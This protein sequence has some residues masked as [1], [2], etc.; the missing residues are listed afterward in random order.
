MNYRFSVWTLIVGSLVT[1]ADTNAG[2][3]TT[4]PGNSCNT[5]SALEVAGGI[6]TTN[7]TLNIMVGFDNPT[8]FYRI[9][10][11]TTAERYPESQF[12]PEDA[13]RK[14]NV[15]WQPATNPIQNV[16][17]TLTEPG[18]GTHHVYIQTKRYQS[19]CISS[20]RAVSVILAPASVQT[21]ALGGQDLNRFVAEAK[22]RGY[23]FTSTF[24]FRKKD[25]FWNDCGPN[26]MREP[27]N[28]RRGRRQLAPEILDEKIEA[29]FE[30]F[31]G[32]DLKPFWEFQYA[33]ALHPDLPA[34]GSGGGIVGDGNLLASEIGEGKP[35]LEF[36]K[37]SDISCPYCTAQ[38][39]KNL[40][41]HLGWARLMWRT[42]IPSSPADDEKLTVCKRRTQGEPWLIQLRIRGPAGEDPINA[43]GDLREMRPPQLRLIPPPKLILPRGV[44]EKEGTEGKGTVDTTPETEKAP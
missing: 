1:L 21:Y 25:G 42:G 6:N 5:I 10:E 43:L 12:N 30:I 41:R 26:E 24:T 8:A 7:R 44:D 13:F 19:G 16:N 14:K 4:I 11:F 22:L 27:K 34:V 20:P 2:A 18:Y 39:V 9:T 29:D 3:A 15:P 40:H 31:S 36:T 37:F 17:F 33:R 38:V 32:P 28:P 35:A 23:Q